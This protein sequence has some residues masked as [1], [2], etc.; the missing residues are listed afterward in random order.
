VTP[1]CAPGKLRKAATGTPGAQSGR[2]RVFSSGLGN[3]REA[4]TA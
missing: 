2:S 3:R 1:A 4:V